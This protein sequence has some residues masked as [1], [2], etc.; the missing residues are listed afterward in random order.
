VHISKDFAVAQGWPRSESYIEKKH[1]ELLSTHQLWPNRLTTVQ[2][3]YSRVSKKRLGDAA[4]E[5]GTSK[6]EL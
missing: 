3:A 1:L 4:A 5:E 6:S 2:E